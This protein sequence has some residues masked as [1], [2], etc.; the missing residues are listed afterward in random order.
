MKGNIPEKCSIYSNM[1][2]KSIKPQ[3]KEV[4]RFISI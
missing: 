2:I 3:I 1:N 4:V